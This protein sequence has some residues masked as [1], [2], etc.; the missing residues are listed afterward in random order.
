M[1]SSNRLLDRFIKKV[2]ENPKKTLSTLV[3]KAKN[4]VEV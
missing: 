3:K 1:I 4:R 2:V